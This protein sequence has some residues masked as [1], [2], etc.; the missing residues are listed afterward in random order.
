[1]SVEIDQVEVDEIKVE[2]IK[3]EEIKDVKNILVYGQVQGGKTRKIIEI[4][5][6]TDKPVVLVIQNSLLVLQQY[7]ER[8]KSHKV[9]F[10]IL[11]KMASFDTRFTKVLLVMNNSHRLSHF[12]RLNLDIDDFVL[13][14]DESDMILENILKGKKETSGPY[15]GQKVSNQSYI[16]CTL[17]YHV[18]ATPFGTKLYDQVISIDVDPNYVGLVPTKTGLIS[19]K[20]QI[21]KSPDHDFHQIISEFISDHSRDNL[22]MLINKFIKVVDMKQCAHELAKKYSHIPIVLLTSERIL[23]IR[24]KQIKKY[25]SITFILDSLKNYKR[26]IFI[27]NRLSLRGLSYVSSD[28]SRHLTHQITRI[29]KSVVSF[30]QSCRILGIYTDSIILKLY[31]S[32][33]LETELDILQDHLDFISDFNVESKLISSEFNI[34][35]LKRKRTKKDPNIPTCQGKTNG[36]PC[37]LTLVTPL[38]C[39]RHSEELLPVGSFCC[40]LNEGSRRRCPNKCVCLIDGLTYCKKHTSIINTL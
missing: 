3:N 21:I 28:F 39:R 37:K 38:H 31:I 7:S 8:L 19:D 36:K 22:T 33:S 23:Y 14:L 16:S 5:Q 11:D 12:K 1:M 30:V 34:Q 35:K 24:G 40:F 25:G 17:T 20:L 32:Y 6:D 2:E 18:T 9:S 26:V 27:A 4:I 10:S 29:P 13:I 15:T